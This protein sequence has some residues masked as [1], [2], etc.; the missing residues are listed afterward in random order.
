M[1]LAL[2]V[3]GIVFALVFLLALYLVFAPLMHWWPHHLLSQ[4][5]TDP[6]PAEPTSPTPSWQQLNDLRVQTYERN[7]GLFLVH[8]CA[9][10]TAAGQV[11]DAHICLTQHSNGPLD[12]ESIQA[13]EYTFGPQFTDH[14]L[15]RTDPQDGYCVTV[16]MWGPMLCLAK[17]YFR[18]GTPPLLLE[19]YISFE[20]T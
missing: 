16:S 11:V 8:S 1:D 12:D 13:V 14:S 6:P 9:P 17:V 19:R 4:L 5:V 2:L 7:R 10:S 3:P 18:D 20:T 15:V